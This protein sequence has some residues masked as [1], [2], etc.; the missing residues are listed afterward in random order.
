[1]KDLCNAF[2]VDVEDYFQVSGFERQIPRSQWGSYE[3]RV[4]ENTRRVLRLLE[5]HQVRATFFVLGWVA[6]RYPGLVREIHR[7]GHEIGSHSY[8]HRLIYQQTPEEFRADL[9]RSRDV[10]E[11]AIGEPVTAYR[12]PSFSITA[13]SLW[14]IDILAE[15][16]FKIDSSIF[17]VHHDRYGIP[18]APRD[19]HRLAARDG[20]LWEFPPSVC[21]LLGLN[22]PVSGGGYF[23]LYPLSLTRAC[24]RRLQRAGK[25]YMFYV[26]PWELDPE[27]P[28]L[29]LG[30]RVSR[31]RHYVNIAGNE[32][33]LD[34]LLGTVRFGR[35]T[36]VI[37]RTVGQAASLPQRSSGASWQ[38]APTTRATLVASP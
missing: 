3:S 17:P 6:E 22:V 13:S 24:I 36:D 12:A 18:G 15:E 21:R 19:L 33:K 4:V 10:I 11:D 9:R 31:F 28:R 2:T 38:L 8:W 16:G 14:A 30:S 20:S 35:I 27:Q 23:R 32:R 1:V 34:A 37:Q 5:R 26:H 25:P 7:R 29:R